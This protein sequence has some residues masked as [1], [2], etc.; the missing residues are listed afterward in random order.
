MAGKCNA[1]EDRNGCFSAREAYLFIP[2]EAIEEG[3]G[4][5]DAVQA[6]EWQGFAGFI[7]SYTAL[8]K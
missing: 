5:K 2:D 6:G 4:K 3:T 7:F 1:M 8:I